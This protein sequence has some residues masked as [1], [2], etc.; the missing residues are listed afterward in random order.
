MTAYKTNLSGNST[1]HNL[2][3]LSKLFCFFASLIT[4]IS[5][6]EVNAAEKTIPGEML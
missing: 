3:K 5:T 4:F 6:M 2:I 1:M